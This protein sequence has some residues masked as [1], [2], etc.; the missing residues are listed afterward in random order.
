MLLNNLLNNNALEK[1]ITKSLSL[2][3]AY[4]TLFPVQ[5]KIIH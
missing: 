1:K 5:N 4:I 3:I 2:S